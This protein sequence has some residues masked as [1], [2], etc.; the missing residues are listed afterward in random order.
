M[1]AWFKEDY[2]QLSKDDFDTVYSEY[3]DATGMFASEEFDLVSGIHYINNRINTIKTWVSLQKQ[4]LFLLGEP[5]LDELDF[6]SKYGHHVS[7]NND[8]EDFNKQL[9][10]IIIRDSRY[11]I[12]LEQKYKKLDELKNKKDIKEPTK[13]DEREQFIRMINSLGKI[14]FNIDKN[15]TTV[16]EL[17]L[18]LKQQFEENDKL[19]MKYG[20]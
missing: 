10:R 16:E 14:G 6:L 7:W 9:D 13:K 4:C 5:F 8:I 20:R 11:Q 15:E 17:A 2:S 19:E 18:M 12:D 3:I 1:S